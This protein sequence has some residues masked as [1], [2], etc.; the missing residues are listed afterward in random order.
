[1]SHA[2]R[3]PQWWSGLPIL[4]HVIDL[5]QPALD[6]APL[7]LGA[8]IS[9]TVVLDHGSRA[10]VRIRLTEVE[11]Y[12]GPDDPASHAFRG[13]TPRTAVMFGPPSHLYVYLSYG[14]HRC[15][16]VVC[17]PDGRAS[18][19]LL[20]AGEVVSGEDLARRRRSGAARQ[21]PDRRLACGPGN[22]GQAL[23]AGLSDSGAVLWQSEGL[24]PPPE[25]ATWRLEPPGSPTP[26]S[27]SRRVG[28]SHN[29]EKLWRFTIPDDP[30]VSR[31]R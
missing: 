16:N 28:I 22:L 19:V 4:G 21:V 2:S 6:V 20:R 8:V 23:G 1:M 25:A 29:A 18:A 14:I 3:V 13:P 11:A 9:H 17:S 10:E 31:P 26:C 12:M 15:V 7:L 5:S 27:R 24:C 30:T